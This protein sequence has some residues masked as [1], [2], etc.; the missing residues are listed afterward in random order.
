MQEGTRTGWLQLTAPHHTGRLRPHHHTSYAGLAFLL[1]LCGVLLASVSLTASAAPPAVNPQSGS[2]G[3]TGTVPGPPPS[4][5]AVITTPQNGQHTSS[6]PITVAGLC[7]ANDF[8]T[9]LKNNV[10]A[11]STTCTADGTFSLQADLF[12]GINHLIARTSDALG[13]YGPDSAGVDV[14]YDAPSLN[15]QG[16]I[17]LGKQLFLIT[18]TTVMATSPGIALTR[19]V[20]IVGGIGPYAISWDWGDGQ[21]SLQSQA[22]EGRIN[23]THTYERA[24]NY[25]VIVRASDST[26]N[27]AYLQLVTVVNGPVTPVGSSTGQGGSG[28]LPGALVTAWPIYLV[29]VFMVAF[30]WLGQIVQMVRLRRQGKIPA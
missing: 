10:F 2:V 26:G 17:A 12:D 30:F 11:G 4:Q 5:A 21:T 27:T 18:D 9:I 24:G 23:A 19:S 13:Q 20:T 3:L 6:I 14:T 28:A 22:I 25:R 16:N 8:I 1:L 7:T 29:A 15:G